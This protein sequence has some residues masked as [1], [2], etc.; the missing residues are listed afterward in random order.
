MRRTLRVRLRKTALAHRGGAEHGLGLVEQAADDAHAITDERTISWIMD[1]GLDHRAV[2][3]Q[4]AP[5]GDL[6]LLGQFDDTIVDLRQGLGADQVGPADHGGVVGD[7]L[8]V[9]A[10]E[11]AQDQAI[12]DEVF[13]FLVA[14]LVE[15]F[16]DKEAQDDFDGCAVAAAGQ[17][18]GGAAGQVGFDALEDGII[19]EQAVEFTEFGLEV[20][21]ELGHKLKEVDRVIAIHDHSG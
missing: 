13:G 9:E 12:A 10:A 6:E 3:A 16:D 14:P 18:V 15:A 21:H 4:L 2:D 1:G 5:A 8:E 11:L 17:A 20:S 19:V 7:G